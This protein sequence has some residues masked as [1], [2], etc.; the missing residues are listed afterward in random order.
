M[1]TVSSEHLIKV[2][3]DVLNTAARDGLRVGS[4]LPTER[5][6]ASGLKLTRTTIRNAMALLEEEGVV[7]R[8]VG[9]GTF[10]RS[11]PRTTAISNGPTTSSIATDVSP[12]DVMVARHLIEPAIMT[13]VVDNATI[14]D[15]EEIERCL[16]GSENAT[17]YEDVEKWDLALHRAMMRAAHNPLMEGMYLLV[18]GARQGEIWGNM[19]RRSDSVERRAHY[20]LQHRAI[21]EALRDRDG[22]RAREAMQVHLETVESN[23]QNNSQE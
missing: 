1:R 19:K 23:L 2:A 17:N 21:A 12:S 6:L 3:G 22:R 20:R 9:R 11:D 13:S 10:L 15:F 7:S 4:R 18:E 5:E 8:E 16:V 14:H